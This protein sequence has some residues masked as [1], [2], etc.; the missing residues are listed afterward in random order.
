MERDRDLT[1]PWRSILGAV[2]P[3]LRR[4][5]GRNDWTY[6][7]SRCCCVSRRV[8]MVFLLCVLV[9]VSA[10]C[11]PAACRCLLLRVGRRDGVGWT[12]MLACAWSAET[13]CAEHDQML[14]FGCLYLRTFR[15]PELKGDDGFIHVNWFGRRPSLR[16]RAKLFAATLSLKHIKHREKCCQPPNT[17]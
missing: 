5:K 6:I 1:R 12:A 15:R 9:W 13:R 11:L 16:L 7:S 2:L 4:G 3:F 10:C 14:R 8:S 17:R